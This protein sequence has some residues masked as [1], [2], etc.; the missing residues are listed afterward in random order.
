ML[1]S[2][3]TARAGEDLVPLPA[4]ILTGRIVRFA[5]WVLAQLPAE[6]PGARGEAPLRAGR[7]GV[8]LPRG[9][10]GA[11]S[12][13]RRWSPTKEGAHA[14]SVL[15]VSAHPSLAGIPFHLAFSLPLAD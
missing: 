1:K 13:K 5:R 7:D 3:P 12:S 15:Q 6:G 8:S 11:R 9:G 2:V 4:Q 14:A 10:R